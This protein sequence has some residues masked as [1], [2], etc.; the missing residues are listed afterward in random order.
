[1]KMTAI[2]TALILTATSAMAN[3]TL[4]GCELK[5]AENATDGT[6]YYNLVDAT[7]LIDQSSRADDVGLTPERE[8]ETPKH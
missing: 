8:V 6:G 1:M 4:R 7:C 5:P 2:L 3:P